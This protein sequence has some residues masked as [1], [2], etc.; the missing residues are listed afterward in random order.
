MKQRN[1]VWGVGPK[2]VAVSTLY[3]AIVY[4]AGRLAGLPPV[5]ADPLPL[6]LLGAVLL[7]AGGVVSVVAARTIFMMYKLDRLYR[8]GLYARCRHPL[9]ADFIS[10][11]APG[12]CLLLNSWPALTAPF[13]MYLAFRRLIGQEERGLIT[14]FGDEY[15]QYKSE[16]NAVFPKIAKSM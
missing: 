8:A 5:A 15:L 14:A 2:F 10:L 7:A 1:T 13:F 11:V 3:L 12:V 6:Q 9:Y 4:T 16:V